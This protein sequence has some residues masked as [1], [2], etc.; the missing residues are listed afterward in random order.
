[1]RRYL[2]VAT[3]LTHSVPDRIETRHFCI[4]A[5]HRRHHET[6]QWPQTAATMSAVLTEVLVGLSWDSSSNESL[7]TFC[8][9]LSY[10]TDSIVKCVTWINHTDTVPWRTHRTTAQMVVIAWQAVNIHHS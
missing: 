6:L 7:D 3:F 4:V 9:I 8:H 10:D 5:Y 2:S 1:L